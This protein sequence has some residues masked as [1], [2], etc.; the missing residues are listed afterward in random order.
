MVGL[1][2]EFTVHTAEADF[3]V[4]GDT[5]VVTSKYVTTVRLPK[6]QRSST[7]LA[8]FSVTYK[9]IDGEWLAVEIH[10]SVPLLP[11]APGVGVVMRDEIYP[12]FEGSGS[13]S[14]RQ[15]RSVLL[16][17]EWKI[18]NPES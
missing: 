5:A 6:R 1:Y 16:L 17:K 14:T 8:R 18:T 4:T 13:S 12:R 15:D 7:V 2:H 11:V 3:Q 9:K 10:S